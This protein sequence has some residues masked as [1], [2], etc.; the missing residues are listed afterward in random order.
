[1]SRVE[2]IALL[3]LFL[4]LSTGFAQ[5]AAYRLKVTSW[6]CQ[7]FSRGAIVRGEVHNIS[8]RR[9]G[10]IRVHARVVGAGLRVAV[11]SAPIRTRSLAAGQRSTFEVQVRTNFEPGRC[12][13]WFRNPRVIQI[14]TLVPPPR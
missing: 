5:A 1:M 3:G 6:S 10:E 8:S 14:E 13:V 9:I 11:N 2:K 4:A 12:T 7:T